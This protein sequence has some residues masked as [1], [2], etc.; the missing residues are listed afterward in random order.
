MGDRIWT[1]NMLIGLICFWVMAIIGARIV[2]GQ[3]LT[4]VKIDTKAVTDKSAVVVSADK[5]SYLFVRVLTNTPIMTTVYVDSAT[6]S[7]KGDTVMV[8]VQREVESGQFFERNYQCSKVEYK[9]V[10]DAMMALLIDIDGKNY[11]YPAD[12]VLAIW[13][14]ETR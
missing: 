3:D 4:T 9:L 8:P 12:R 10:K 7:A 1:R 11:T 14:G 6:V 13:K 5:G 2:C